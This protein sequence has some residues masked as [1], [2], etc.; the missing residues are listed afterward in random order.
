MPTPGRDKAA[1]TC[2]SHRLPTAISLSDSTRVSC[3]AKGSMLIRLEILALAPYSAVSA[4]MAQSH[5]GYLACS[6]LT[7]SIAVQIVFGVHDESD[8]AIEVVKALQARY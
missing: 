2:A 6:A 4:T 7:T 5:C 1:V 3:L 8:P